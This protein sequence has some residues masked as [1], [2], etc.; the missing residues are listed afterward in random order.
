MAVGERADVFLASKY[1]EYARSALKGLFDNHNVQVNGRLVKPSY[2]LKQGDKILIDASLLQSQPVIV[3]LPVLYEDKD[4]V[5]INKP[6]GTLTH[7]KGMLNLESTV[8]SFIS[9][10]LN[11]RSLTGNRAGI[12]HRLD[13]ATSGIIICARNQKSLKWL[14][15]QFSSRKAKKTYLAFVDGVPRAKEAIIDIPIGRN[16]KRPQTFK[17]TTAG[18]PAQTHYKVLKTI[19]KDKQGFSLV[20][21]KPVTGRTHQLRLHLAYIGSPIAGDPVYGRGVGQMLLHASQ[22]ELVLPNGQRKSFSAALPK[23][24]KDFEK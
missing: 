11:D 12:V 15:Q 24:F 22:L 8:A 17:A 20:E 5:V 3:D 6:A 21:L 1:P 7:S 23:E 14:Q 18:K 19:K 9:S 16:P 13:R 2:R 10:K 4:V